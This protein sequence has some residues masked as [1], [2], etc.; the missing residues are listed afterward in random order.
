MSKLRK[1]A[2]GQE[3]TL[4]L[5]GCDGGGE[6]TILAHM[7]GAGMGVKLH[8]SQGCHAC[9]PCHAAFDAMASD[10]AWKVF[11]RAQWETQGRAIEA[12]LL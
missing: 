3:C 6:T 12:G 7:R 8:D 5:P 1:F 9:A 11:P 4:R 10:D 2:K